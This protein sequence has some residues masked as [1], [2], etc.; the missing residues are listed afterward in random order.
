MSILSQTVESELPLLR[1][2][3]EAQTS[4]HPEPGKWSKKEELGHLIDSAANNHL[5]FVRAALDGEYEGPGYDPDGWVALHG[6]QEMP[7]ETIIGLWHHYNRLLDRLVDRIEPSRLEAPC[8]VREG[9]AVTLGFLIDDYVLHMRHHL[10]HVLDRE[11]ITPY[12][13]A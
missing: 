13:R 1:A 4:T 9:D 2:L 3:S 12:P 6:Y 11:T 5:R 7:V 8:V 10:D